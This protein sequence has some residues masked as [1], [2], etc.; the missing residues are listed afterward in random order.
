MGYYE[1]L[2]PS[3]S[4][5]GAESPLLVAFNGY[6]ENGD[7]TPTALEQ[8]AVHRHPAV[9]RRRRLADRP[10]ARRARA[11]ARRGASRLRLLAVRRRRRGAARATCSS[12]TTAT[13]RHRPSARRRTRSTTSSPTPSPTTTSTPSGSTSPGCPAARFGVWEYL[14]K[15]GDEQVAAAVPIAGDG[16]P[17][18]ATAGC[19]L[20]SVPLW[21][22]HGE[23]DDVVDPQGSI[24]PMTKLAACPG[25]PADRAQA[26][27]LSRPVPRRVGS[28][29]Q[30]VPRRRHLH[31][32]ARLQQA[33]TA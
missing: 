29:V 1:Y 21:A 32:D 31:L 16:R 26:D 5:T 30:R 28:G 3:Y 10:A 11:P 13:T 7:G 6:G 12:S 25:V 9:H 14:A 20:G 22:F 2:P 23:L 4:D 18:W 15:Y 19:G 24:E 27:R 17:A 8:A 33:V